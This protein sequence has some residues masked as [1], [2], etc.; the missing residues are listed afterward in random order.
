MNW[1]CVLPATSRMLFKQHLL[2]CVSVPHVSDF[3]A[4][5]CTF[6]KLWYLLCSVIK[7]LWCFDFYSSLLREWKNKPQ[8]WNIF[9]NQYL[10]KI[11][12]FWTVESEKTLESPQDSK[13]IQPV[14]RKGSQSWLCIGKIDAEAET[15]ILWPPHANSWLTGKDPD[16]GKDLRKKETGATED[17]MV[18]WHHW[19]ILNEDG[20]GQRSLLCCNPWGRE[21]SD[22][23]WQPNNGKIIV[24]P[25]SSFPFTCSTF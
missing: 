20:E 12:C 23:T 11:W 25:F 4:T 8:S 1:R 16:A 5:L 2:I 19:F 9:T 14:H 6:S 13:E 21:V 22:A 15:P 24:T 18:G 3:L 17:D 7:D 10:I